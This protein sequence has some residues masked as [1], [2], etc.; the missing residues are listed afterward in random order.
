MRKLRLT[1]IVMLLASA[2]AAQKQTPMAKDLPPY[3]REDPVQSPS[4]ISTKLNNGLT[5]WLVSEPKFPK[6]SLEIAVRSGMAADPADRP[7]VSELLSK[8][9]DQGTA[10]RTAKQIAEQLQL[11]G[12]DLSVAA[13]PDSIKLS[14]SV[15]SSGADLVLSVLADVV[16]N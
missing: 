12:G 14:T 1:A 8:T 15:L 6:M 13:E 5:V 7:G 4:V 3:G 11:A 10:S 16:Q 2:A 9:V